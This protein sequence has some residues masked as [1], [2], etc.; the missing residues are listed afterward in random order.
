M[1]NL[2]F[3]SGGEYK[4]K[5]FED[6]FFGRRCESMTLHKCLTTQALR[7]ARQVSGDS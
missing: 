4:D 1:A 3:W 2:L 5:S 7:S 6:G